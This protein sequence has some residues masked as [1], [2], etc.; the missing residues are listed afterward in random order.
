MLE[1]VTD[2]RVVY[3]LSRMMRVEFSDSV[4]MGR[5]TIIYTSSEENKGI[6]IDCMFL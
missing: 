5:V 4:D 1:K 3:L 6:L 2:I